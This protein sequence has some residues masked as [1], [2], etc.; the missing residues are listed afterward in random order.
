MQR[1]VK[2]IGKVHKLTQ[3]EVN[4]TDAW[5]LTSKENIVFKSR[6]KFHIILQ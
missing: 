6:E 5:K 2:F 3:Y 4:H 1:S